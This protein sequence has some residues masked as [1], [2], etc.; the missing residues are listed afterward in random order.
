MQVLL[1]EKTN[2]TE[3][4]L[5]M[6]DNIVCSIFWSLTVLK[7]MNAT[8]TIKGQEYDNYDI[9]TIDDKINFRFYD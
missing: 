5:K 7:K 1:K 4:E 2:K 9:Y 6:I 3:E 8:I